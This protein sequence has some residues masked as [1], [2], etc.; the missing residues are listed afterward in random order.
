MSLVMDVTIPGNLRFI[1]AGMTVVYKKK[2]K[3]ILKAISEVEPSDFKPGE[4]D[5]KIDV[6]D[7]NNFNVMS[8]V[9]TLNIK[10]K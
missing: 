3:G 8:A 4:T 10:E 9:I 1:P 2:A 5:V 7:E 6:Y